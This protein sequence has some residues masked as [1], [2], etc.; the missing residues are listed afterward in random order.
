MENEADEGAQHLAHGR[1]RLRERERGALEAANAVGEAE[2][3]IADELTSG[4]R[5]IDQAR[6]ARGRTRGVHRDERIAPLEL[7][8][9]HEVVL[10]PGGVHARHPT[11]HP[12][13]LVS[14]EPAHQVE[15]VYAGVENDA[16]PAGSG[17]IEPGE[18]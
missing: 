3:V 10:G 9:G 12:R 13:H 14:R 16:A 11:P 7:Q 5:H 18:R 1:H 6:T 15:A 17:V 4:G 8:Q 2:G